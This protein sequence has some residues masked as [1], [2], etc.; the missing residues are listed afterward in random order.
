MSPGEAAGLTLRHPLLFKLLSLP[1]SIPISTHVQAKT[2]LG[3]QAYLSSETPQGESYGISS[4]PIPPLFTPY[5]LLPFVQAKTF[6]GTQ[7]YMSPERLQGKPYNTSSEPV[8]PLV[9]PYHLVPL[10]QAKTFLGTQA[11]MSPE[12]LQGEPYDISS[13]PPSP[14]GIH[15]THTG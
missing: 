6:L 3:T 5:Y 8:T 11:Y 10:I 15:I 14:L 2:F 1:F 9:T 12:R 7:A 4:E 13:D